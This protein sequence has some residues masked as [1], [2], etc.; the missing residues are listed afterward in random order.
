MGPNL[1]KSMLVAAGVPY[2]GWCGYHPMPM[3]TSAHPLWRHE[4]HPRRA[5]FLPNR[6]PSCGIQGQVG[7]GEPWQG[8]CHDGVARTG[9]KAECRVDCH[10]PHQCYPRPRVWTHR[11]TGQIGPIRHLYLGEWCS[12]HPSRCVWSCVRSGRYKPADIAGGVDGRWWGPGRGW[13]AAGGLRP[14]AA[15][16]SNPMVPHRRSA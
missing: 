16:P 4:G 5:S 10:H 12:K 7:E 3:P 8:C 1:P 2:S 15:S 6:R 14:P 9:R 11:S 13:P